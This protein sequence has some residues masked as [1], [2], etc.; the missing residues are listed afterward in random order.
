MTPGDKTPGRYAAK[1][2]LSA[3]VLALI[4]AGAGAPAIYKQFLA[5]REGSRQVAYL[6][7]AGI[8]T[9][10]AGLT[11]IYG[12]PVVQGDRL[13]VDECDRLDSEEQARGLAE[14]Q[15]LVRPDV[16]ASM[17]PAA[18][19][20]TASF[21]VHNIGAAKCRE[22]TFLRLLNA[23]QR[24]EACAQITLWIR[25]GGRDCRIR[26]NGCFGQVERRPQEDELCLSGLSQ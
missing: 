12:R 8:W 17:S 22:S 9:I 11:R 7:S 23:G 4:M 20:G 10:C 14:M 5:E 3:A 24:N 6:D 26:G 1:S 15:S 25:D 13:S 2:K 19:A 16:W 21:C 18:R